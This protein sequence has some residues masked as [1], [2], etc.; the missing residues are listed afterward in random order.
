MPF[1]N[2]RGHFL[3]SGEDHYQAGI[4]QNN[5]AWADTSYA[6]WSESS[7]R[8]YGTGAGQSTSNPHK[9]IAVLNAGV[10]TAT[11]GGLITSVV[12]FPAL[13]RVRPALEGH[14]SSLPAVRR[15]LRSITVRLSIRA[16]SMSGGDWRQTPC[17][18]RYASPDFRDYRDNVFSRLSYDVTDD[19]NAYV[20]LGLGLHQGPR[21]LDRHPS[22]PFRQ[23]HD[24]GRQRLHSG[25]RPGLQDDRPQPSPSS[26][27]GPPTRTSP[28]YTPVN[29]RTFRRVSTGFEGKTDAFDTSWTW[30]ASYSRSTTTI[31][32]TRTPNDEIERQL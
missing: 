10:A 28:A 19:I 8:V 4:N 23:R 15:R 29:V 30:A 27:W 9:Y 11:R 2:D 5:R 31:V 14:R 3:I 24:Q 32:S 6:P 18:D 26:P 1:A 25:V 7:T 16:T 20:E 21:H 12:R 17:I 13:R 22:S